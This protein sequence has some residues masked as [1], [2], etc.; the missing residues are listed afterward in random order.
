MLDMVL[1]N[2]EQ[3]GLVVE[4]LESLIYQHFIQY[5]LVI[6]LGVVLFIAH[7][8]IERLVK[9][10]K[11]HDAEPDIEMPDG[12]IHCPRCGNP[13]IYPQHCPTCDDGEYVMSD[14][15]REYADRVKS[16]QR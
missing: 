11:E 2:I 15:E 13:K 9:W 10:Q 1:K 4:I 12:T 5:A 3:T 6:I 14:L 7:R 8:R 16:V